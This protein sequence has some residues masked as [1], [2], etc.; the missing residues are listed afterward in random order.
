MVR[1]IGPVVVALAT[2]TACAPPP[3]VVP[4]PVAQVAAPPAVEPGPNVDPVLEQALLG[5]DRLVASAW[6]GHEGLR[7]PDPAPVP[8]LP[9]DYPADVRHELAVLERAIERW[10]KN[11][12]PDDDLVGI[13]GNLADAFERAGADYYVR[14]EIATYPAEPPDTTA[15]DELIVRSYRIERRTLLA[16]GDHQV[17]VLDLRQLSSDYV[18]AL[19]LFDGRSVVLVD[20]IESTVADVMMPVIAGGG[21]F[22]IAWSDDRIAHELEAAASGAIRRELRGVLGADAALGA[23]VGALMARRAAIGWDDPDF[24]RDARAVSARLQ[25][26]DPDE[27]LVRRV[28]AALAIG[29]RLHEAQHAL[30]A[31]RAE[32]LACPPALQRAIAELG[33]AGSE[34]HATLEL[35]A[36]LAEL[37]GDEPVPQASLWSIAVFAFAAPSFRADAD[38]ADYVAPAVIVLESI[39]RQLG[40]AGDLPVVHDGAVDRDRLAALALPMASAS[41]ADMRRA[42]AAAWT[43][44]FGEPFQ[45]VSDY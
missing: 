3:R 40:A 30:D 38:D 5:L 22:P 37:A 16:A 2:G 39:A 17:R 18:P 42:A 14:V 35:S 21:A 9:A 34:P 11:L 23:R 31:A 41:A 24:E 26:L 20:N 44:L 36:F 13:G 8:E 45:P 4:P 10:G 7:D 1:S 27:R 15:H 6:Y 43:E 12:K 28:A 32:P 29:V 33:P 19:G 25:A